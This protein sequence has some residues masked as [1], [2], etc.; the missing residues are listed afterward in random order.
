MS[1][2]NV[3]HDALVIQS[4]D[5]LPPVDAAGVE[6]DEPA[7][8]A[9]Y[10]EKGPSEFDVLKL[11]DERPWGRFGSRHWI[12]FAL[13][14]GMCC[15]YMQR[16]CIVRAHPSTAYPHTPQEAARALLR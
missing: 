2:D 15:Q 10:E 14:L 12:L 7:D 16:S 6:P 3:L 4:E 5:D 13:F 9:D 8:P 11:D 1:V